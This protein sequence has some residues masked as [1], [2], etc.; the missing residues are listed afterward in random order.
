MVN[1]NPAFHKTPITT[2]AVGS[3]E[4]AYRNL[5]PAEREAYGDDYFKAVFDLYSGFAN[6][7]CIFVFDR[8][9]YGCSGLSRW[10]LI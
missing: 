5:P 1:I 8:Y 10:A 9:R 6:G 7:R 4:D 2:T 3:L